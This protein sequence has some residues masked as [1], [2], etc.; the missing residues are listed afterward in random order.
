MVSCCFWVLHR[1][2]LGQPRVYSCFLCMVDIKRQQR[3]N[4]TPRR[5]LTAQSQHTQHYLLNQGALKYDTTKAS[6]YNTKIILFKLLHRSRVTS[7]K[8]LSTTRSLPSSTPPKLQG[9][10]F[11]VTLQSTLF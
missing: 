3:K 9:T 1:R 2:W 11:D 5:R 6:E 4:T 8:R 7:R 10:T